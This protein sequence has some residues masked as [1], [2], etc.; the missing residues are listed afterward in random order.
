MVTLAIKTLLKID[1]TIE[2]DQGAT[3]RQH[4]EKL[5][6]EA[7]DAFEGQKD[8][9]RSHLGVSQIG[10]ECARELWYRFRWASN[11]SVTGRML[12]LF[13]R[14][15]LEEP[16]LVA[17]LITA[18]CKV[19]SHDENGDQFRVS[20][21]GGHYGS[22]IDAVVENCPDMPDIPIL[23]EFKTHNQKS[24]LKLAGKNFKEYVEYEKHS[25]HPNVPR[26]TFEGSGVKIAKFEHYVQMQMYMGYFNLT[27]SL[28]LAV[29]KN[30]DM[31]Y[32][33]IIE[34][35]KSVYDMYVSRGHKIVFMNNGIPARIA[36]S[37]GFW[38]CRF[39]D[40]K[41]LCHRG[42][43]P[44]KNCRTCAGSKSCE[45]GSW[46]CMTF[47]KTINKNDQL[48]ACDEHDYKLEFKD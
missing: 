13:N 25:S 46:Q 36:E 29:D 14:G 1:A 3:F 24:F 33:E 4:L 45:D 35:D 40:F 21:C 8:D 11:T 19:W 27:H 22:A 20:Y 30:D 23:G 18:E 10:R 16:R 44:A 48:K 28:Y 43:P 31:L 42:E 5:I 34:F 39:C 37:V 7:K 17:A 6:G 47:E 2:Q 41:D 32:A 26:V 9:F 15:H 12:R 38:K